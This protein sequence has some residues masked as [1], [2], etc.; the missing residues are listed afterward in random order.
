MINLRPESK[1]YY[2]RLFSGGRERKMSLRTS[3][4]QEAQK[5]AARIKYQ[6]YPAL[7]KQ[8]VELPE[9]SLSE[10]W[11][12]YCKTA[13]GSQLKES[14]LQ[15][16]LEIFTA[17]SRWLKKNH[18]AIRT[19]NAID[20]YVASDYLTFIAQDHAPATHNR[21]KANLSSVWQSL[22]IVA[23]LAENPWRMVQT[24]TANSESFRAFSDDEV[25]RL[26]KYLKG[27][28]FWRDA[29]KIALY[30]GLRLKDVI[31]LQRSK[32]KGE[33][34]DIVPSKT[35]RSKKRV[36]IPIHD[37]IKDILFSKG[38]GDYYFPDMAAQYW[39]DRS[40][41]SCRFSYILTKARIFKSDDGKVGFHSL[42]ATFVTNCEK[43]GISRNVIQGIVGHSSPM[44]TEHYSH[45]RE[46]AKAIME[47][48]PQKRT[49]CQNRTSRSA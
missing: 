41:S 31:L 25:N 7:L 47:L 4:K 39:E 28:P 20:R 43:Y 29:V 3:N 11:G 35:S 13:N 18:P 16:K 26:L 14:S 12:E 10:A 46:S 42:R 22:F 21:H 36:H 5:R 34:I 49:T 27:E 38:K 1:N 19:V 40:K 33:A 17:F 30:T 32:I 37:D 24:R 48:P 44:M 45:D 23:G 9:L 15:S 6:L 2:I 8:A